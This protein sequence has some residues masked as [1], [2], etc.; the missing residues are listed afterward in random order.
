MSKNAIYATAEESQSVMRE[1]TPDEIWLEQQLN[2]IAPDRENDTQALI[3]LVFELKA[4]I[5]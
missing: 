4:K 1:A 3:E 2:R 5:Q